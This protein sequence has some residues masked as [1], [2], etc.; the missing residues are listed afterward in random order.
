MKSAHLEETERKHD[1]IKFKGQKSQQW[2][3]HTS[4]GNARTIQV[5][6]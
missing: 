4:E 1:L 2:L 3:E 5:M 6:T